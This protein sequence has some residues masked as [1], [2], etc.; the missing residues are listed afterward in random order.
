MS[1]RAHNTVLEGVLEGVHKLF[2]FWIGTLIKNLSV[3]EIYP[4]KTQINEQTPQTPKPGIGNQYKKEQTATYQ[5][6]GKPP[7]STQTHLKFLSF[8][9]TQ[10]IA[11]KDDLHIIFHSFPLKIPWPFPSF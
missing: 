7:L 3:Q 5:N 6:K 10:I 4:D 11:T 9:I 1:A 8:Q 2:F